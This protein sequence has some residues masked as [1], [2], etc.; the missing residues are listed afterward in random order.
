M[1]S[2]TAALWLTESVS[3]CEALPD[4]AP[5]PAAVLR[6][7]GSARPADVASALGALTPDQLSGAVATADLPLAPAVV[8]HI[9][10]RGPAQVRRLLARRLVHQPE[11]V[12]PR[13]LAL[14]AYRRLLAEEVDQGTDVTRFR[15]LA[16]DALCAGTL[17]ADQV[18]DH[19]RPA[20][21]ALALAVC[22][23]AEYSRP[24]VRRATGDVRVLLARRLS[25]AL[26]E[27]RA[28]WAAAIT[29]S[30][31][32]TGSIAELPD[33][34]EAP[35]GFRRFFSGTRCAHVPQNVLLALAPRGVAAHYLAGLVEPPNLYAVRPRI[36]DHQWEWMLAGGPLS[37]PLVQHVL[38]HGTVGQRRRLLGNDLCPDFVLEQAHSGYTRQLLLRAINPPHILSR[39]YRFLEHEPHEARVW[40]RSILGRSRDQL[41][42]LAW[43]LTDAP[44]LLHRVVAA[45]LDHADPG[46]LTCLYGALAEAAGPEPVWALD[47]ERAGSLDAV[48]PCVRAS[49]AVGGAEP[50]LEAA[51]QAPRRSWTDLLDPEQSGCQALRGE[52]E[53]DRT[54]HFPLETLVAA[55]LDGRPERWG[56]VARRVAAGAAPGQTAETVI[57]AT[58]LLPAAL[59]SST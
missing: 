15:A 23:P 25:A 24:W 59:A 43:S 4:A 30:G 29:L 53:L 48:L 58:A 3:L 21:L 47:L 56:E 11:H 2:P 54:G 6:L 27:D 17:T 46:T 9:S 20:A 35:A 40:A 38:E 19:T 16:L 12:P 44:D 34:D 51:R 52:A 18:L 55:H 41:M 10:Q 32:F 33:G 39:A 26:G 37:R 31:T 36:V 42:D 13:P 5:G 7:L 45:V 8:I 1:P 22:T 50:L 28:R 57:A 14:D 49:M